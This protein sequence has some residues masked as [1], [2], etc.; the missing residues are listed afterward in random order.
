MA[1]GFNQYKS[2][3][4][5]ENFVFSKKENN[6]GLP[7]YHYLVK[8][9]GVTIEK[10]ILIKHRKSGISKEGIYV[11]Y[12]FSYKYSDDQKA[13]SLGHPVKSFKVFPNEPHYNDALSLSAKKSL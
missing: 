1:Y 10:S 13:K 7:Y 6:N 12:T 2:K 3:Y 11:T 5:E 8:A 9:K 4:G